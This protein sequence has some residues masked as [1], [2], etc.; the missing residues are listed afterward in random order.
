MSMALDI[1]LLIVWLVFIITAAK[2]GFALSLLEFAAFAVAMVLAYQLSSAAAPMLYENWLEP[3]V[4]LALQ[5]AL[6]AKGGSAAQQAQA[7]LSSLPENAL[8]FAQAVGIDVNSLSRQINELNV[9]SSGQLAK[10]LAEKVGG[11]IVIQM[12]RFV[13]FC[14]FAGVISVV[15]RLLVGV[16]DR[17][18][19][20]PIIHTAD[21]LLG[22][23][24]GA[25][26]GL[27]VI[28]LVCMIARMTV[29]LLPQFESFSKF[30]DSSFIA[31]TVNEFNPVLR[32]MH[33]VS[34][35]F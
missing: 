21:S 22:G 23:V 1:I 29:D 10:V 19:D 27:F 20:L 25:V 26:K 6:P 11:P 28:A 13:L 4:I 7:V 8:D 34:F 30:V 2:K 16:I 5:E 3:K 12:C 32:A 35:T 33:G 24:F 18:F 9:G 31:D 17:F 14:I 15:L